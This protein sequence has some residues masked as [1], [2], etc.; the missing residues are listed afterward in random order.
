M[1]K[2]IYVAGPYTRPDPCINTH[3]AIGAANQLWDMGYAPFIPHLSHFWHTVTPK[4]YEQWLDYDNQFLPVCDAVL[5][6]PGESSGADK[7]TAF[8]D[9]LG[10]PVFNS[11]DELMKAMPA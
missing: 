7:E 10:I 2:R 1:R 5:R 9:N 3:V 8:A 6:L 11:L 4:P